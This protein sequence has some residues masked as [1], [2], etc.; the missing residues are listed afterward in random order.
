MELSIVATLYNSSDYIGEFCSRISSC[1]ASLVDDFE[2]ILVDDGSPDDSLVVAKEAQRSNPKIKIIELSKNF[3]HHRAMMIG[4]NH[5]IGNKT[6]LIDVDLEEQPEDLERYWKKM[7]EDPEIDVVYGYQE[8]RETPL[9]R[10]LASNIFHSLFD[11]LTSSKTPRGEL[12]SRLMSRPYLD[13]LCRYTERE[14]YLPGIWADNGFNSLGLKATKAHNGNSNYT[15]RRRVSLAVNAITSFSSKPLEL[16]FFFGALVS[17]VSIVTSLYFVYQKIAYNLAPQGWSSLMVA[18]SLT[19]GLII[20]SIGLVGIYISKIF[21]E[22]KGRPY[23]IIR[24]I[25]LVEYDG[26]Q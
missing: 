2:I 14:L 11:K 10:T 5:S 21:Q 4:L 22:V 8:S 3:G 20:F 7:E 16:V 1:A 18:I 23:G 15:L 17:T 6:F 19:G 12:V 13:N 9:L 26:E 24:E 25:H